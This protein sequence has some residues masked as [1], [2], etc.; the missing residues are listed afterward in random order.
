M[1]NKNKLPKVK[2]KIALAIFCIFIIGCTSGVLVIKATDLVSANKPNVYEGHD[3]GAPTYTIYQD[4]TTGL[5]CAKTAY[6]VIDV[7]P[8]KDCG[9]IFNFAY[10]H[11]LANDAVYPGSTVVDIQFAAGNFVFSSPLNI[12][13]GLNAELYLHG[14]GIAVT[15]LDFVGS[16]NAIDFRNSS[17]VTVSD[18][19][20]HI[21][22]TINAA[23]HFDGLCG[24][25]RGKM[26][27]IAIYADANTE[28]QIGMW[29]DPQ[30]TQGTYYNNFDHIIFE[31][32]ANCII[33]NA[34]NPLDGAN[35][36]TW[37]NIFCFDCGTATGYALYLDASVGEWVIDGFQMERQHGSGIY[38]DGS[39]NYVNGIVQE[40]EAPVNPTNLYAALFYL[41]ANSV[42]NKLEYMSQNY[43]E[44]DEN[45]VQLSDLGLNNMV[46][47][48]GTGSFVFNRTASAFAP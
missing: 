16:G 13:G 1:N 30:D 8:S 6:G 31:E 14:S 3:P 48:I 5:Y 9:T 7:A 24:F 43:S 19:S 23:I 40:Y 32:I 22:P 47:S 29:F 12:N 28:G 37:N 34:T 44:L 10:T 46:E 41:D 4:S 45:R 20:I 26:Q 33:A 25:N 17:E 42:G 15:I 35:W 27:N 36:A 39:N 38:I 21:S 2:T 11:P 18:F